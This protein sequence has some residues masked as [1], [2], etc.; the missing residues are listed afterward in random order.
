MAFIDA[1]YESCFDIGIDCSHYDVE[2]FKESYDDLLGNFF[3]FHQNIRSF[4]CN[5]DELMLFLTSLDREIDMIIL[6]ETWFS[7]H[8]FHDIH[9]YKSYHS[10][11]KDRNGGG[12][13]VF[14]SVKLSNSRKIADM[15]FVTPDAEFC[16]VNVSLSDRRSIN[17]IGYYRPPDGSIDSFC[18]LFR[19]NIL[20]KFLS[21]DTLLSGGDCNIDLL[22]PDVNTNL[23]CDLMYSYSLH[24]YITLPTRVRNNSRT[25]I[26]HFWGN[27][28][29]VVRGGLFETDITDHY[30]TFVCLLDTKANN[31]LILKKF[32][33]CSSECLEK[34]KQELSISL[35]DF[36]QYDD[37]NVNIKTQV[38]YNIFW[39][40][41]NECCPI[42]SKYVSP[43]RNSKPWFDKDLKLLCDNKFKLFRK[44]KKGLIPFD[45][46]NNYK[47]RFA[48]LLKLARRNYFKDK[49]AKCQNDMQAT[50]RNV[51]NLIGCKR[52]RSVNSINFNGQLCGDV[53]VISELFNDHFS[54]VAARLR[55]SIPVSDVSPLSY[56]SARSSNSILFSPATVTEVVTE[57]SGLNNKS[58]KLNCIPVF[59]FK[60]V[61][62]IISPVLCKLFNC[63]IMEGTFPDIL[64]IAE[65]IPIYKSG[66]QT[67]IRN[68]RPI[69]ILPVLSK[70]F[71]RLLKSRL[72]NFLNENDVLST[73]QFGFQSGRETNDAILEFLDT[74]YRSLDSKRHLATVFLDLSKAFDT[75]DHDILIAKLEHVG[76]RGEILRWLLSYLSVRKQ[77]VSIGSASSSTRDISMGVPQGSIL[78][79]LLFLVYIDDMSNSSSFLN[80]IHFADDT[81]VFQSGSDML[82]LIDDVNREF[83]KVDEWLS[84]N[85]LSLNFSK[86]EFMIISHCRIPEGL[87]MS[88]R[89]NLLSRVDVAKFLGVFIDDKLSFKFH[90]DALSRKLSRSAGMLYRLSQ[91]VPGKTL[92]H[93]Y[94]ALFHSSLC[95]GITSWG[96]AADVYVGRLIA[97][98]KRAVNILPSADS[99]SGFATNKILGVYDLYKYFCLVKFYKCYN[100]GLH[101]YFFESFI[102]LL[103]DHEHGTRHNLGG[104]LNV[105]P[106]FKTRT[107]KS[108]TFNSSKFWNDLPVIIKN[109]TSVNLFKR[110]YKEYLL[111]GN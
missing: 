5:S 91:F 44:Y 27:V 96:S 4:N 28:V 104:L 36:H 37:L 6:S 11:R 60:E 76:V 13:S 54:S 110:K 101:N 34:L 97:L 98:Q 84:T 51:N 64:K 39:R 29:S 40:L 69:S 26:D 70:L 89:D 50:W 87:T 7:E 35:S 73:R 82:G 2:K 43:S 75:L 33:D 1:D 94:F 45:E 93:L 18:R 17:I 79:P 57:I 86:T 88:V 10:Y 30:I 102:S 55:D 95:Y 8:N 80:F 49:F 78:G 42:R 48:S 107:Q 92:I 53:A 68:Y 38:F 105:P 100:L 111:S 16:T 15:S 59:I 21:S 90:I 67:D 22:N 83:L 63:S 31:G 103:P 74:A 20:A 81:T 24:P 41:Y 19:E 47:N 72:L 65:V 109:S 14:V 61:R 32:R 9:G 46:Y 108:F 66:A 85:K 25:L 99:V 71:E 58:S 106:C 23:Y 62:N 3:V 52:T 12:V 56:M 77:F